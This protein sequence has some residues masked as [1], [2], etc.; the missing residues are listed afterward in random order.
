MRFF[1]L[2]LLTFLPLTV[3]AGWK[4]VRGKPAEWFQSDEAKAVAANVLSWQTD[5]GDWPKNID[6]FDRPFDGDGAKPEGTFDNGATVDEVRFLARMAAATD[7]DEYRTAAL[8]SIDHIFAAQYLNGGFPQ[9]FPPGEGYR[10]Y[11]TF[12][13]GTTVNLL[14][15]LWEIALDDTYAFAGDDRRAVAEQMVQAGVRCILACQHQGRN[16]LTIWAG[17]YDERTLQPRPARAFE[18][19]SLASAESADILT[20]LM[21]F[22]NPAPN[23]VFAVEAGTNWFANA[24][25]RGIR[26]DRTEDDV[27]VVADPK[28]P[29]VWARFYDLDTMRPLFAGRDGVVRH[30]LADIEQERRTGY[31]WYGNWGDKVLREYPKWRKRL[32]QEAE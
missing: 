31:A 2:M 5:K 18:P 27:T 9:K 1:L 25:L 13:D 12:N 10:R 21:S 16:G 20:F 8:K 32:E 30:A 3:T 7:R 15:L 19:A 4:D 11:I 17:Q 26:I 29:P 28:A 22:E 23:V 14:E 6:T 24:R